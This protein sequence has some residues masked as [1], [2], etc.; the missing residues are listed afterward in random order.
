MILSVYTGRKTGIWHQLI[1]ECPQCH[2]ICISP[3]LRQWTVN[4][5]NNNNEDWS[6]VCGSHLKSGAA[7]GGQRCTD[8]PHASRLP[9]W[10]TTSQPQGG[11]T[12]YSR[13]LQG[14]L[15]PYWLSLFLHPSL[16]DL[17]NL[18]FTNQHFCFYIAVYCIDFLMYFYNELF[19]SKQCN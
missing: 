9:I 12:H 4:D 16:A 8:C 14:M 11:Q 17:A 1:T 6:R 2:G 15:S 3:L 13:F 19:W 5:D 7:V 10:R 18:N